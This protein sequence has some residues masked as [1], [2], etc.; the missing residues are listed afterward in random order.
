MKCKPQNQQQ[1]TIGTEQTH[2]HF[3]KVQPQIALL[4]MH[5]I[6][7]VQLHLHKINELKLI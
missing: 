3:T 1:P 5:H 6:Q 7:H 2:F 4:Y